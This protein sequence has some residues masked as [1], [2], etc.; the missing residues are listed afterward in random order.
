ME[1]EGFAYTATVAIV[2]IIIGFLI[3]DYLPSYFKKKGENLATKEDIGEITKLV[4]EVKSSF[5][6][7]TEVLKANLQILNG[8][9]L[10]IAAEERAA[11]V[12]FNVKYFR[13]FYSLIDTTCGDA[14]FRNSAELEAYLKKIKSLYVDMKDCMAKFNLFVENESLKQ[15]SLALC[16]D[17]IEKFAMV[18]PKFILELISTNNKIKIFE[19]GVQSSET[20]SQI[21]SLKDDQYRIQ[22]ETATSNIRNATPL[23]QKQREFQKS[24]NVY[25]NKLLKI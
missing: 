21:D 24:C 5:N 3:K 9:K 22:Q 1:Y 8:I 7:E 18:P 25:L 14:D 19:E 6:Q 23:A 16:V 4:E 12:D 10:G 17:T 13:W 15:E 2:G 11:I 20:R